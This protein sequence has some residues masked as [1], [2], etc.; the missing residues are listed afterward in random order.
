M[1]SITLPEVRLKARLPEGLRDMSV[2]DIQNAMSDVRRPAVEAP[3]VELPK[4]EL[5]KVELPK[6]ELPKFDFDL[7]R[8][9]NRAA[10]RADK[11]TRSARKSARREASKAARTVER[12]LPRRAG[13][14]PVPI[15]ILAM[16][17]GVIVG[18]LL[19]TNPVTG[20]R[21][22]A[23]LDSA[24]NTLSGRG[25]GFGEEDWDT[26]D[27]QA[28]PASLRASIEPERFSGTLPEDE[29]GIGVGPGELPEGLGT[30][31]REE[32]GAG[33]GTNANRT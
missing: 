13:P 24:R 17:G 33:N 8:E 15:A 27:A 5:P 12:A 30:S 4:V 32:I 22:R 28:Y 29:T 9:A 14:N 19:A 26:T 18:W 20:P 3:K 16:L 21:V 2:Q 7:G 25:S 1:P 6:V 10:R 23:M 11:A 31:D